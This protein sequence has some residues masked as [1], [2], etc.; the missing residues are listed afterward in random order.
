MNIS[1]IPFRAYK[2]D[3]PYVFVS[4]AHKDSQRVFAVLNELHKRKYR[5]WYDEG[6]DPGNEWRDD[7]AAFLCDSACFLLFVSQ[8]SLLSNN[9]KNEVLFAIDNRPL[10]SIVCV[11]LQEAEIPGSLQCIRACK[12][13]RLGAGEDI[14]ALTQLLDDKLIQKDEYRESGPAFHPDDLQW[15]LNRMSLEDALARI[16][17]GIGGGDADRKEA[18]KLTEELA[19]SGFARQQMLLA[20]LYTEAIGTAKNEERAKRWIK[21]ASILQNQDAEDSVQNGYRIGGDVKRKY[22]YGENDSR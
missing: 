13:A 15:I 21:M 12:S 9:V 5:I 6:I 17:K 14:A 10:E 22:L 20:I 18:F 1:D 3:E 7:I 4:Y 16:H 8:N 11:Y 19:Y 2:G